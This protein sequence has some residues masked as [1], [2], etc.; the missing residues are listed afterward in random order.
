MLQP[1]SLRG[2]EKEVLDLFLLQRK[3][4]AVDKTLVQQEL[5]LS[6][7][8]FDK[9]CSVLLDKCYKRIAP[10]GGLTLLTM[11]SSKV[12]A[13][14]RH[15]FKEVALQVAQHKTDSDYLCSILELMQ[16]NLPVVNQN[17]E[18]FHQIGKLVQQAATNNEL[19]SA[20]VYTAAKEL[21]LRISVDFA[22]RKIEE[23]KVIHEVELMKLEKPF[24]ALTSQ[25]QAEVLRTRV[26][27]H[28]ACM[29]MEACIE[30]ALAALA[31]YKKGKFVFAQENY[32]RIQLR[33]A[34]VYYLRSY[35]NE[36]LSM[37][38]E[39]FKAEDTVPDRGY[40]NTKY[41]QLCLIQGEVEEAKHWFESQ[42]KNIASKQL[43]VIRDIISGLK[44]F[45]FTGELDKV[46]ELLQL[47]FAAQAKT[48]Y[49]QY[50]IEL[51]NLE[52]AY[53]LFSQNK[54][55]ALQLCERN[56]KYLHKNGFNVK[57]SRYPEYF[58]LTRAFIRKSKLTP[59]QQ[60]LLNDWQQEGYALYGRLLK[61]MFVV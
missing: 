14:E 32:Q 23:A 5:G 20:K 7:S 10:D 61:K 21:Y 39:A 34:E 17:L 42:V 1:A 35:F 29:Q 26:Y 37:F 8:H 15:F 30:P 40:Y 46:H 52:V 51:R 38:R 25:A 13:L 50:E 54:D 27:F 55:V 43:Y 31:I 47:G 41:I 19:Q 12:P 18:V 33:L 60:S 11:L 48:R 53:F 16:N 9:I 44:V 4:G 58:M 6:Q 59:R 2:K 45:L 28:F 49:M 57:K 3:K 22:A 24:S 36:A 56:V